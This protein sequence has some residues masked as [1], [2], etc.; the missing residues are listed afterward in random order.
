MPAP[1]EKTVSKESEERCAYLFQDLSIT[2]SE[3][4]SQMFDVKLF[5]YSTIIQKETA[6]FKKEGY[7]W[8]LM[9]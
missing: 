1:D 5:C 7:R 3:L 4:A 6:L 8:N 9:K 2:T